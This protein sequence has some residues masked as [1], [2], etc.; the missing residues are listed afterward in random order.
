MNH[1]IVHFEIP[2]DDLEGLKSFYSETFGWRFVEAQ[3]SYWMIHTV[4]T[5]EEGM[6]LEPGVNG[7][8]MERQSPEHAVTNYVSVESVEEYAEKIED[9]GGEIVVEKTAVPGVGYW[10]I[11]QD[12]DGNTMAIMEEDEGAG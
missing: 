4:P 3:E 12:P 11:F 9:A 2:A 5:D 10:A 8:M 1:T 6:P 7:G